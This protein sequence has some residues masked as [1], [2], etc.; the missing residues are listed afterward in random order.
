[1]FLCYSVDKQANQNFLQRRMLSIR[2]GGKT[3][4][5]TSLQTCVLTPEPEH[6]CAVTP[7]AQETNGTLGHFQPGVTVI[8]NTGHVFANTF[9]LR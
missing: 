2:A 8:N 9:G 4:R 7:Y 5:T 3:K 6:V 1:M